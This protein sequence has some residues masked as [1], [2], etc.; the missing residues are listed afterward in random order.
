MKSTNHERPQKNAPTESEQR[1]RRANLKV[2]IAPHSPDVDVRWTE[3]RISGKNIHARSF[4]SCCVYDNWL[5]IYGGYEVDSGVLGDFWR[6]NLGNQEGGFRWEMLPAD[7]HDY[8]GKLRSHTAVAHSNSMYLF[9]GQRNVGQNSNLT[10]VYSFVER[11]W[12]VIAATEKEVPALDSHSAVVLGQ[13]MLI[14]GGYL[15]EAAR[16]NPVVYALDL[17]SEKWSKFYEPQKGEQH[18]SARCCFGLTSHDDT[19]WLFGGT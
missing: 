1:N 18:P 17:S 12:K 4:H 16:H 3:L 11:E 13:N 7:K 5:Y 15:I 8:P 19:V 9:G 6:L 2:E 10:Y 14:F